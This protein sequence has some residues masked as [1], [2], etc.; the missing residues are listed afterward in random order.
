MLLRKLFDIALEEWEEKT[1]SAAFLNG[2]D[3]VGRAFE[4]LSAA[5]I[6]EALEK[7]Q[8]LPESWS[9]ELSIAVLNR[10]QKQA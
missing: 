4:P 10:C 1:A 6:N 2:Q 3:R 8:A 9:R 5:R 7:L